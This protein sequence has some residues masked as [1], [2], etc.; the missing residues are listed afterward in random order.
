MNISEK[1]Q[2]QIFKILEEEIVP[3]EGCTEPIAIA[4]AAS[5][6]VEVLKKKPDT[7]RIFVSGNILKNAKSVIVPN[8]GG[9]GGI[10]V[11]A[12]MGALAGDAS[13][14]LL[15]ISNVT[16][17]DMLD[18][19]ALIDTGNVT[20]EVVLNN[21]TLYVMIEVL[22][23]EEKASVEIKHTHTNI[24]KV[25]KNDE[26]LID[27]PCNDADFNSSLTDRSILTI[28]KIVEMA[29]RI[30]IGLIAPLFEKVYQFNSRIAEEGLTKKY[31]VNIGA[32]IQENIKKGIY[33]D[34][35]R[36][37][38]AS[39]AAA[40]SDARM[41]GCALPVM[42]TSGSGNQGMTASLPI[43]RY[44][45]DQ[46]RKKE[47][48]YRALMVS[49]LST[50]HIKTNV[51]R[52]SAYCGVMTASAAVSGALVYLDG[53]TVQQVQN[54]IINTLGNVSGVIC[55]GANASCAS[56]IA[57]G[58]YAAFDGAML[59]Q[60]GNVFTSS[61][62]IVDACCEETIQN[63]GTLAQQGMKGTDK[64]ILDIMTK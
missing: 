54:G 30:D 34:D 38:S 59:S 41:G 37:R 61:D 16:E 12:T 35:Q 15:V 42:T 39:Y 18:V 7:I 49:H 56:K 36:N 55:D 22:A 2:K 5:K 26:V 33:G 43:I 50:V 24:T 32:C 53:G 52:L 44:C 28:E 4:F 13:K 63:V 14:D 40:G 25:T 8:S 20:L 11:A 51:G 9:M 64:T 58:I 1:E 23:G 21:I 17:N 3:A 31:G 19:R 10:E 48:M 29:N 60:I 27:Q 46:N 57:S 45:I 6:A 62:G 47:E